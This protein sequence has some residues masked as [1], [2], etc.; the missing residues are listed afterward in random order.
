MADG[1]IE[2]MGR[3][4]SQVKIRGFRI[5]TGEIETIL[6]NHEAI[7]EA[8]VITRT[9]TN[10]NVHLCAYI[11]PAQSSSPSPTGK[12][13]TF[14]ITE[15]RKYLSAE[16]PDHMIPSYFIE[17]DKLPLTPN[18]KIDRKKLPEPEPIPASIGSDLCRHRKPVSRKKSP[19]PGKKV[20]NLDKVGSQGQLFRPGRYLL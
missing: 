1:S 4:D 9:D 16:L 5:E 19:I 8:V 11:V 6:L 3:K 14:T 15:L 13:S 17:L 12:A 10:G 18:G 7:R 2:C 20:L